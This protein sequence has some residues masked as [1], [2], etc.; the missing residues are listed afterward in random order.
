MELS[1]F[2]NEEFFEMEHNHDKPTWK[3]AIKNA[4]WDP[5]AVGTLQWGL[6]G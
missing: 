4:A 3:E 2:K 1:G 5:K 6:R